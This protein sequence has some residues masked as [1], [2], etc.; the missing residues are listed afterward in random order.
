MFSLL[1][2]YSLY[3]SACYVI[4]FGLLSLPLSLC[5]RLFF[6]SPLVF[7]CRP[8]PFVLSVSSFSG[9][10]CCG[11]LLECSVSGAVATEYGDLASVRASLLV[12]LEADFQLRRRTL[13]VYRLL[14]LLVGGWRSALLWLMRN[15]IIAAPVSLVGAAAIGRREME[16]HRLRRGGT[17]HG[18]E[19]CDLR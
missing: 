2:S 16:Q 15:G 9:F 11:L 14:L 8:V 5:F 12:I 18:G 3:F 17:G 19:S 4:S 1:V 7:F 10:F 6:L 13:R